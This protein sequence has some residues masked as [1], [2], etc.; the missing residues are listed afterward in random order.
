MSKQ[1]TVKRMVL[2]AVMVAVYVVLS[3]P[4]MVISVGGLKV[5]FEH[6]PVVLCA[7]LFGPVD[8]MMVGALGEFI[9]QITSFGITPTTLLWILPI[10]ARGLVVGLCFK[11][12]KKGMGQAAIIRK[13]V[14]MVFW[15]VC[16]ISGI[17]SSLFN[18]LALYVDSKLFGYYTFALV[19][20]ALAVR[21]LL[22]AVT[23]VVIAIAIKPI[24]HAFRHE[25]FIE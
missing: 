16:I 19:F 22:S 25:S 10:V 2:N 4:F 9:N 7:V 20:G 12:L 15:I 6:F 8:A 3:L 17:I 21:L 1:M 5:T 14:P 13:K 23:S 24:L 11:C 18:T